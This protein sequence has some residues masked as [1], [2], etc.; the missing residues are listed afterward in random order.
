MT[1]PTKPLFLLVIDKLQ[2]GADT[3]SIFELLHWYE[4]L[5]M[6]FLM[7]GFILLSRSRNSLGYLKSYILQLVLKMQVFRKINFKL[8]ALRQFFF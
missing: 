2:L 8:I 6:A 4:L 5:I 3:T 7:A 1:H